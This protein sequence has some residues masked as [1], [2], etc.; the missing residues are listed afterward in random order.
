MEL[1]VNQIFHI[2]K[3]LDLI[4]KSG[5]YHTQKTTLTSNLGKMMDLIK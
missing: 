3:S 2:T 5:S 4:N 1:F